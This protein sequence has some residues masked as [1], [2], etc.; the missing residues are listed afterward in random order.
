MTDDDIS[1]AIARW[2]FIITM[3]GTAIYALAVCTF[4]LGPNDR[5]QGSSHAAAG[6]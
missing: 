2:T 4:V 3:I 6:R 5:E 1:D